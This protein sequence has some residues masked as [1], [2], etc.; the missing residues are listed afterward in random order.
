MNL[1]EFK[2][3]IIDEWKKNRDSQ[4]IAKDF[5]DYSSVHWN[6]ILREGAV[7]SP[8]GE[9]WV[10]EEDAAVI[11]TYPPPLIAREERSIFSVRPGPSCWATTL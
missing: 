6:K 2:S 8:E 1:P 7:A 9:N 11:S 5:T 4:D 3:E 10:P